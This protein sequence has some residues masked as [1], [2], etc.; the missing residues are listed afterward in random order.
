VR[1]VQQELNLD[2]KYLLEFV[3]LRYTFKIRSEG[4]KR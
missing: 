4:R 1:E 2:I 3:D